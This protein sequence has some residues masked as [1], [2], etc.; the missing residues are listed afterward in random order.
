MKIVEL[1]SQPQPGS[2]QMSLWER[3]PQMVTMGT[4]VCLLVVETRDNLG[5]GYTDL[6]ALE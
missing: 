4:G 5:F 1:A 6:S 3:T 2:L